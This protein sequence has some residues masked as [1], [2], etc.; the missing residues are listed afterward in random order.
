MLYTLLLEPRSHPSDSI[1][2]T[3]LVLNPRGLDLGIKFIN[4]FS[5]KVIGSNVLGATLATLETKRL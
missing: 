3:K 1:F 2:W 4:A 5:G